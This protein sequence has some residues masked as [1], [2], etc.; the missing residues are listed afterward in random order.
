MTAPAVRSA[1]ALHEEA[2]RHYTTGDLHAAR[3][4]AEEAILLIAPVKG[5]PQQQWIHGPTGGDSVTAPDAALHHL[6]SNLLLLLS[7]VYCAT[8]DFKEAWRLLTTCTCYIREYCASAAGAEAPNGSSRGGLLLATC[9]YNEAVLRL[10]QLRE[11]EVDAGVPASVTAT[12]LS[13][14]GSNSS[15]AE[16]QQH[17]RD[18]ILALLQNQLSV[19]EEGLKHA[20][21]AARLLLAD[22]LHTKGVCLYRLRRWVD[23]VLT[24][25]SSMAIRVKWATMS[26]ERHA[27]YGEQH[28][29]RAED[30]ATMELK[31]ALTM[32]HVAQVYR[33]LPEKRITALQLVSRVAA[34]RRRLIGP[35]H[36]LYGRTLMTQGVLAAEVGRLKL[37]L[38]SMEAAAEVL[39]G[40]ECR[41][42]AAELQMVE[43]W[44]RYL[45]AMHHRNKKK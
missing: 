1:T 10:E 16:R 4:A 13:S 31:L 19:A 41:V 5:D 36:L 27:Q 39:H 21:G 17:E 25:Q 40:T 15:L 30:A 12:S 18:E 26:A 43:D 38:A 35:M 9:V 6:M 32:E 24:W 28:F 23:A 22:V 8:G 14:V 42:S 7:C 33:F 20:T 11:A 2:I 44:I 34:T 3:E 45:T 29:G 37:A